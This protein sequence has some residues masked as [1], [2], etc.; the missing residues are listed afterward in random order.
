MAG[1]ECRLTTA[2]QS[3]TGTCSA[4]W[5][6]CVVT[7]LRG[8]LWTAWQWHES[9]NMPVF[10]VHPSLRRPA[11][12]THTSPQQE[13]VVLMLLHLYAAT[14]S[15]QDMDL[16]CPVLEKKKPNAPVISGMVDKLIICLRLLLS[17][18]AVNSFYN[19]I[20]STLAAQCVNSLPSTNF[21]G[22]AVATRS[23][24]GV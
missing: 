7:L 5:E 13:S 15:R 6:E 11:K 21:A 24:S 3:V 4:K 8:T 2:S 16:F 23:H 19:S 10:T 14:F 9:I 20:S 18:R 17:L 1:G 12:T 22:A